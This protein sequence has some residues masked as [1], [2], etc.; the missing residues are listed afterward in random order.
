M[1]HRAEAA[2]ARDSS[3]RRDRPNADLAEI[4]HDLGVHEI[5]LAMQNEELRREQNALGRSRDAYRELYDLA[6]VGYLTLDE[7]GVCLE[8]NLM[9]G[10]LVG[11]T[12]DSLIGLPLPSLLSRGQ[13]DRLSQ[14]LQQV[15]AGTGPQQCRLD[16]ER[17]DGA[18]LHLRLDSVAAAGVAGD[19]VRTNLTDVSER[20][21]LLD[22]LRDLNRDLEDRVVERTAALREA[23]QQLRH[24]LDERER[25]EAE[26][27]QARKLEAVGRLAGGV[28]HDFNNL[29]TVIQLELP[30]LARGVAG[31][32]ALERCAND[33]GQAVTRAAA[34][35][36]RL[37]TFARREVVRPEPLDVSEV[38]RELEPMVSR[39]L[40]GQIELAVVLSES[41]WVIADRA[42]LERVLLNLVV[43]AHE[44]ITGAGR[45]EVSVGEVS[46]DDGEARGLLGGRAGEF[47]CL[48]VR[49]T[50]RGMNQDQ[51]SHM[52]EPFYT[53]KGLE[54][55]SGLGLATVYG[56][57]T[58]VGGFFKVSSTFGTGTSISIYLPR[59]EAAV[60]RAAKP[61]QVD[62]QGGTETVLVVDD[63]VSLRSA[64]ARI[65]RDSG[66][67]VLEAGGAIEGLAVLAKHEGDV[68]LV[69]SDVIMPGP[70]GVAFAREI[71]Q[72]APDLPVILMSGYT[73]QATVD[74]GRGFLQK[75][76]EPE[77]LLRAVRAALDGAAHEVSEAR[78]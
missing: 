61:K 55:G 45:V 22:E 37:L 76:F 4:L 26:L 20:Q 35:T 42:G 25:I 63:L 29:L 49:D 52:F 17:S 38:V 74:G 21:R 54:H 10:D 34:L 75:P 12:R 60:E 31:Q 27:V 62:T 13:A 33:L 70:S 48:T 36:A 30:V 24:E 51:I 9:A 1:R 28:A 47:V 73:D 32:P 8:A 40:R 18:R 78:S 77:A 71:G 41:A 14:H 64:L 3:R 56:I 67:E 59:A 39:L 6:P 69:V 7:R 46:L 15:L 66:Y 72:R 50:G 19:V 68:N 53:T 43:N 23:N 44:A 58:Q 57:V 11:V 16:L 5:E 65:L 2:L